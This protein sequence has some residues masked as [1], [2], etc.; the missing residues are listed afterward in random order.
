MTWI[1]ITALT[2]VTIMIYVQYG[3]KPTLWIVLA[4]TLTTGVCLYSNA[5][6]R[7]NAREMV[8]ENME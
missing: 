1:P 2:L 7:D 4:A 3:L 5:Y 6:I 8:M